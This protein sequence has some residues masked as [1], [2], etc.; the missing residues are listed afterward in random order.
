[1]DGLEG[2][3]QTAGERAWPGPG[4]RAE[5]CEQRWVSAG[6]AGWGGEW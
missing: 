3:A 1:M 5:A 4:T 6:D 2:E